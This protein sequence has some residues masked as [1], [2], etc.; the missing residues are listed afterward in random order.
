M[1]NVKFPLQPHQTYYITQYGEPGFSQL[2]RMNDDFTSNSLYL[3]HTFPLEKENLG[4]NWLMEAGRHKER[5][6]TRLACISRR[7]LLLRETRIKNLRVF[8]YPKTIFNFL[9]ARCND[10]TIRVCAANDSHYEIYHVLLN[11]WPGIWIE[12]GHS[13]LAHTI[14]DAIYNALESR[15]EVHLGTCK[16]PSICKKIEPELGCNRVID[17]KRFN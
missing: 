9:P 14:R 5:P 16:S 12:C 10:S 8:N 15:F 3:M 2:T 1:I 17:K 13:P 7:R 6:F 11:D 4:V